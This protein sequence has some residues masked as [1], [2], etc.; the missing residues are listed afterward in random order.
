MQKLQNI[1]I[2]TGDIVVD[3]GANV[4]IVTAHFAEMG[5]TVHA[6]EPNPHAFEV[7]QS[8]FSQNRNVHCYN[9]AVGTKKSEKKMKL[10]LHEWADLNQLKYSTGC[11]L[12]R[13]KVNVNE[14]DYIT[15]DVIV[16]SE[17]LKGLNGLPTVL[18]ID[19]EGY[20]VE[21]LNELIDEKCLI[22]IPHVLVETHEKKVPS[23]R[24]SMPILRKRIEENKLQNV[25]LDWI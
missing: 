18:K 21:L 23:L 1:K 9:Q 5:A 11:S 20:E 2:N 6:F 19:V 15:V 25:D 16:L 3:C 14:N 4:G 22:N 7:L 17:F 8:R 24:E 13:D 12:V 10:F